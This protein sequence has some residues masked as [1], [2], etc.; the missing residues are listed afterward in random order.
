MKLGRA[1]ELPLIEG[2]RTRFAPA[3]RSILT[4][5]GDDCAVL[6]PGA[7]RMVVTT[8]LM[9][10]GVHFDP[11]YTTPRQLGH[12]LISVNV[13]D[14]YAMGGS[15][16][17][18]LLSLAL[19]ARSDTRFLDGLLDGVH[20]ALSL[21]RASLVGGDISSSGDGAVLN[22]TVIG[23]AR[24]PVLRSGARPGDR[25]YVTGPLGDAAAGLELLK[26]IGKPVDLG[27][28]R[29]RPLK[30]SIM[31]PLLHRHLMPVVRAPGAI[32]ARATAMIDISDGLSLD[33]WRLAE[34]SG[35]GARIYEE[36]LPLSDAMRQAA[37]R[38][39]LDPLELA[40]A[41]GEDYELLFT[42]PRRVRVR[43]VCIGEV[44]AGGLTL[45]HPD[46]T[47]EPLRP[48]GYLHFG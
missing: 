42:A 17:H 40:L 3:S 15:P 14:V 13:S 8:D 31:E 35:V 47:T 33:L 24:R 30:W 11:A 25:I 38:L 27:R 2:I 39:C 7:G 45:V 36:R 9:A 43:G 16:A 32:A 26:R 6:R 1:G 44:V 20:E 5:I 18:V 12:K 19:P 23:Y 10:E 34:E 4:G 46:G 21:Y 29:Q 37:A 22:A 41:G 28:P 48:R